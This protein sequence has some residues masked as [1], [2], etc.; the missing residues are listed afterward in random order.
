MRSRYMIAAAVL[1][2]A[3][4]AARAGM[5]LYPYGFKAD[6]GTIVR[7]QWGEFTVPKHYAHPGKGSFKL[8]FVRFPSTNPHPGAPIVYLA[9]GPGGSGIEAAR[10]PRFKLFMALRKV[11][12][13]IALDQRGTGA[14]DKPPACVATHPLPVAKPLVQKTLIAYVKRYARHCRNWWKRKG[15]DASAYNTWDSAKD[16]NML[17]RD[18]G[19]KKISLWGISYGTQLALA[20]MKQMP[21]HIARVVLA[22]PEGPNQTVKLPVRTDRY[23]KRLSSTLKAEATA[24]QMPSL[25]TTMREVIDRLKRHPVKVTFTPHGARKAVTI[26]FGAMPIQMFTVV[27]IKD[28]DDLGRLLG[29]YTLM[30]AGHYKMIAPYIYKFFYARPMRVSTMAL[31]TEAASGIS[32]KRYKV[33]RKQA[34]SALLGVALNFPMPFIEKPLGVP[35]LGPAYRKPTH[36][37]IP[38]LVLTGTL[39][40]RTYPAGHKEILRHLTHGE[41]IKVDNAGHDLLMSSPEVGKAIVEFMRGKNVNGLNIHMPAPTPGHK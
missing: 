17:R 18:L 32:E 20:A 1:V 12:D 35:D 26:K 39:D 10:G 25:L 21:G 30:A 34:K 8:A 9:G 14:S 28:P 4:P 3:M 24:K 27:M 11:A 13:V 38:V 37:N 22:S 29:L 19:V 23:L 33:F 15:I 6:D 5:H 31:A 7:A 2:F 40:G 41:E 16:L 36:S